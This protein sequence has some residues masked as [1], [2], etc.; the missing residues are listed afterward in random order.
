M[1]LVSDMSTLAEIEEAIRG[2]PPAD[3]LELA[4]WIEKEKSA[5]WV[6]RMQAD[7]EAGKLDFLFEEAEA[8]LAAG[9]CKPW[10]SGA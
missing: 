8:A 1:G 6:A 9:S 3:F 7:A 10:P 2:L 5:S 4:E